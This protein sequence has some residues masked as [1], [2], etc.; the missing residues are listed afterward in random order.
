MA[1]AGTKKQKLAKAA[2]QGVFGGIVGY[3]SARF[4]LGQLELEKI[5]IDAMLLVSVGLIYAIIGIFIG[6]GLLAPKLVGARLLNVEDAEEL[7]EQ[8]RILTG[9]SICMVAIGGALI[10]LAISG[11]GGYL[12]PVAGFAA[13]VASVAVALI[14]TLRD[15]K[16]YDE[17]TL[18]VTLE[19]SYLA[20]AVFCLI[21]WLWC[22]G[23]WVGWIAAPGPLAIM[24]LISGLYLLAIFIVAGKRGMMT[25]R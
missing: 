11:P 13:I 14:I 7:T 5:G 18:R 19:A 1:E 2:L 24:A 4:F 12:P 3:A 16:Y 20:F 9:S 21:I 22:S 17:L 25:P 8:R 10:M 23:A 15:W 6:A